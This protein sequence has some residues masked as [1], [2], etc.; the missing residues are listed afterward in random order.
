MK[1][2]IQVFK[3]EDFGNI[4]T[5]TMGNGTVLFVRCYKN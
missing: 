1:H 2:N 4:R 3:N 5:T